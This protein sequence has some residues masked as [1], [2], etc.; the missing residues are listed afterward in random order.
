M[1]SLV[2]FVINE[3]EYPAEYADSCKTGVLKMALLI[4][5]DGSVQVDN[6]LDFNNLGFEFQ[7]K[8]IWL[9]PAQKAPGNRRNTKAK[10]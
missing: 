2:A 1:D 9:A 8:A 7:F 10:A 5:D 6:Q 4:R 3:L